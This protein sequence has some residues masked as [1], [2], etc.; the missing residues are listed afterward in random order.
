MFYL[1][2]LPLEIT[3][4][5]QSTPKQAAVPSIKNSRT[6]E[7][8]QSVTET[9]LE[10]FR[11]IRKFQKEHQMEQKF[12]VSNFRNFG[13]TSQGCA[14]FRKFRKM[15][16]HSSQ[17][18]SRKLSQHFW[19]NGTPFCFRTGLV[20]LREKQNLGTRKVLPS[21][22]TICFKISLQQYRR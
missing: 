6:F 4:D 2:V 17:K 1:G 22:I 7:T 9:S 13:Y 11:K 10:S 12:S 8:G 3:Q 21:D 5:L 20:P 14:V 18:I 15:S 16:F 19:W